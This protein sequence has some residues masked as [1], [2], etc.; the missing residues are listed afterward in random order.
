MRVSEA[1]PA[2]ADPKAPVAIRVRLFDKSSNKYIAT[3]YS[4]HV[5]DGRW[6]FGRLRTGD[7]ADG[8]G[9]AVNGRPGRYEVEITDFMCGDKIWFLKD[10]ILR[11]VDV[12]PGEPAE[13]TIEADLA[14]SPARPSF[15]NKSGAKCAAPVGSE[16][17]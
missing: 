8:F 14:N 10:R 15:D 7:G 1:T 17:Q 13:V 11:P 3:K 9:P 2:P 4:L 5:P 12:K 6:M 16:Q